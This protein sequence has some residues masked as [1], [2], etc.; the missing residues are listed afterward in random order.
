M[1]SGAGLKKQWLRNILNAYR[2]LQ[3]SFYIFHTEKIA[4]AFDH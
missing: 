3:I 1:I 2:K 4:N